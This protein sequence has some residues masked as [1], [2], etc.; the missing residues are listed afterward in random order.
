MTESLPRGDH[1]KYSCHWVHIQ[2]T[3]CFKHLFF[4]PRKFRICLFKGIFGS[5]QGCPYLLRV[6]SGCQHWSL[7]LWSRIDAI[8]LLYPWWSKE[9]LRKRK[10]R[11]GGRRSKIKPRRDAGWG[12]PLWKTRRLKAWLDFLELLNGLVNHPWVFQ[13]KLRD[14]FTK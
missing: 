10:L 13:L 12:Q 7:S 3:F 8:L 11:V 5:N 4:F 6:F 2:C 1:Q 14:N 9:R